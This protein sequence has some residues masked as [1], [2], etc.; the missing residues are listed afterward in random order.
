MDI[1]I[2]LK[3]L[4]EKGKTYIV[5]GYVRD[6]FI[7][8]KIPKDYDIV[9]KL[10][11]NEIIEICKKNNFKYDEIGKSFGVIL[12]NGYEIATFRGDLYSNYKSIGAE[13]VKFLNTLEGDL[14]RRDF[15][16]NAMAL[17]VDENGKKNI[18][19]IIDLYNGRRDILKQTIKFIGNPVLRIIEDP[20]RILRACRF[21]GLFSD[22]KINAES[23]NSIV[24]H[25]YELK[26]IPGERI[27]GELFKIFSNI[28]Y[29]NSIR[30]LINTGISAL[31]WP[32]FHLKYFELLSNKKLINDYIVKNNSL[33]RIANFFS[34]ASSNVILP[35]LEKMKMS[36][37]EINYII[38]YNKSY[39][40]AYQI[41]HLAM[42]SD[43]EDNN[44]LKN[45]I[46]SLKVIPIKDLF[47][48]FNVKENKFYLK[49]IL[50]K[51]NK[52]DKEEHLYSVKDLKI[53]GND[54]IEICKMEQ[55]PKI[56][57][58][59]N[60]LLSLCRN[61]KIKNNKE[62]LINWIEQYADS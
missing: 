15:T 33:L 19:E 9:T 2:L 29:K 32:D 21:V 52:I 5:G 3:K 49:K 62:D 31:L 44:Q 60:K 53:N 7:N 41:L 34:I 38:E 54:L 17:P 45:L 59:L 37:N 57:K 28:N 13:S 8:K 10:R 55:G 39:I 26:R 16:F 4:V 58:I 46:Y 22:G 27:C 11:P 50:N 40:K 43:F 56:G 23:F 36:K 24:L 25:K 35:Y 6:I 12:V 1:E 18:N 14:E 48:S 20:L 42:C 61:E 47:R 51:I 30:Y